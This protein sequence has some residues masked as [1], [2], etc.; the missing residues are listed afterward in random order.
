MPCL[1]CL[2]ELAAAWLRWRGSMLRRPQWSLGQLLVV[3]VRLLGGRAVLQTS[4]LRRSE[5]PPRKVR[6]LHWQAQAGLSSEERVKHLQVRQ[7]LLLLAL[8]LLLLLLLR[9]RRRWYLQ[10]MP[11][12]RCSMCQISS[13][14]GC[15]R[16]G[17]WPPR[18]CQAAVPVQAA[19]R[20]PAQEVGWLLQAAW[21]RLQAQVC[22]VRGHVGG[23]PG[24]VS[25]RQQVKLRLSLWL[26]HW[27][28]TGSCRQAVGLDMPMEVAL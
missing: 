6:L 24:H 3:L 13:C 15:S 2:P 10:L 4:R 1:A 20:G 5:C 17:S 16:G 25:Q 8:L 23:M 19:R 26:L 14:P 12:W 21:L 28:W 11:V 27:G 18:G 7:F 9:R 22:L